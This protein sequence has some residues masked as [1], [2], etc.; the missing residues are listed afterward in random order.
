M[1]CEDC[2]EPCDLS[3]EEKGVL[4]ALSS[5]CGVLVKIRDGETVIRMLIALAIQTAKRSSVA[6]D[7]FVDLVQEELLHVTAPKDNPDAN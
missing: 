5:L 6:P 1:G 2:K 3:E 4:D 7:D